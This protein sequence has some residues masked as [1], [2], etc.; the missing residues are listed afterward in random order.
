M[1][2]NLICFAFLISILLFSCQHRSDQKAEN[3]TQDI[4]LSGEKA[5]TEEQQIPVPTTA[6]EPALYDSAPTVIK[7]VMTNVD[8][9]KKI[10]KTASVKLEVK[11]FKYYNEGLHK[12]IKQYGAYIAG[13]DDFFSEE[14]S[15]MVLTIKVPVQQF[16]SLMNE[17]GGTD[18]K[19]IERSIKTEDV[20]GQ[21]VDTK[22]RL[23]AKKQMRLKYLE[24][25][26]QSKNMAEVLQVQEEINSIQ[27]EIESAEGRIQFLSNQAA[28]S[29]INLI[30]YEPL[31][32]FKP[33]NENPSFFTSA[34]EGFKTGA[35]FIKNLV[36]GLIT[37][38][39]LILIGFI[40]MFLWRRNKSVKYI[41]LHS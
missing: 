36:L 21:L 3:T 16:E 19:V 23:E 30:F 17:L 38:W 25:L 7:P 32:V 12:K 10:V 20:T 37:I 11:K 2:A 40:G 34:A 1:K 39:P 41:Q 26:K 9:D 35:D 22:S 4:S 33:E 8:W 28:Y 5:K 14:K 24:F 29:T 31:L 13:E 15:E 18:I 6:T 27:E